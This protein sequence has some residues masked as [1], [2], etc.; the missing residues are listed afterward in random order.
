[1][2]GRRRMM[3]TR[4]DYEDIA[5]VIKHLD[6]RD[7]VKMEMAKQWARALN[8]NAS[9]NRKKFLKACSPIGTDFSVGEG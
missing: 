1:M 7:D 9:F 6:F 3:W 2:A 8:E 4:K 5:D